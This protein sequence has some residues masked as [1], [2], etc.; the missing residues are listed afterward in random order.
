MKGVICKENVQEDIIKGVSFGFADGGKIDASMSIRLLCSF[1][2]FI[3]V[4]YFRG[5][6]CL[7]KGCGK[8]VFRLC[9]NSDM[10]DGRLTPCSG[11]HFKGHS[12]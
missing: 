8:G 4:L 9:I 1:I 3:S 7:T 2:D 5:V 10:W 11:R 6:I 12:G